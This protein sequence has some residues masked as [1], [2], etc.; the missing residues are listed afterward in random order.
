MRAAVARTLERIG[1][2][3]EDLGGA[4]HLAAA[5]PVEHVVHLVERVRLRDERHLAAAV[6]L[7]Q[8]PEVDPAADEVAAD[9]LLADAER[10][11]RKRATRAA[12]DCATS[13]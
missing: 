11:G 6:Q 10:G 1:P 3:A 13:C 8:L 12:P 7:E 2:H 4:A 5:Q 9:R